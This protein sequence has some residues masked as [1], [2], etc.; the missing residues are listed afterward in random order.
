M[1]LD[2]YFDKELKKQIYSLPTLTSSD[3]IGG[4]SIGV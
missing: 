1:L 2:E 3:E 4:M